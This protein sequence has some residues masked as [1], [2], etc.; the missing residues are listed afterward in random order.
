MS[1]SLGRLIMVG[2]GVAG[3]VAGAVAMK[4]M[5]DKDAQLNTEKALMRNPKPGQRWGEFVCACGKQ[6]K[7]GFA[8][9]GEKQQCRR[10][11]EWVD[12]LKLLS[13]SDVAVARHVSSVKEVH[14]PE[15]CSRCVK[16]QQLCY[17]I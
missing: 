13:L 2:V 8:W 7:S 5:V 9:V 16:Y 11:Q 1:N 14:C 10:C 6:W 15:R 3:G 12:P 4:R 17:Q